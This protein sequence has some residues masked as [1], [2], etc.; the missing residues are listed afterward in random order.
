MFVTW[1]TFPIVNNR[2]IVKEKSIMALL[3]VAIIILC[4]A[5]VRTFFT[6]SPV[7]VLGSVLYVVRKESLYS[8]GV[9]RHSLTICQLLGK[10]ETGGWYCAPD[11]AK[12]NV[13]NPMPQETPGLVHPLWP[14][15]NVLKTKSTVLRR[16]S[17]TRVTMEA[18]KK[19]IWQM[20]P[21]SSNAL[22]S[23]LNHRLN[24]KGTI[25]SPHIIKVI[26]HG[27]G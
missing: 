10:C 22:R 24:R 23:C 2:Q 8:Y 16:A 6:S 3:M 25:I 7:S 5:L 26:C 20:P 4:G 27:F 14:V 12:V 9:L 21:R 11:I 15:V 17:T 19:T 18:I 1:S 13:N